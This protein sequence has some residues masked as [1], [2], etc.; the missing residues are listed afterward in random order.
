[1]GELASKTNHAKAQIFQ[2]ASKPNALLKDFSNVTCYFI[3]QPPPQ[4]LIFMHL[5]FWKKIKLC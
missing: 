4:Y 5:I 3:L 2:L 1:M